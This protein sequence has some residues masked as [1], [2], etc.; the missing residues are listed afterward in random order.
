MTD[1]HGGSVMR[2]ILVALV[3][4]A[5]VSSAFAEEQSSRTFTRE[6]SIPQGNPLEVGLKVGEMEIQ[7]A[8]VDMVTVEIRARC[9]PAGDEKC[10]RRLEGI[11]AESV[12]DES[13]SSIRVT[14]VSKRYHRMEIEAKIT[15]P[16]SSPLAVKMYAG[17]LRVEGG[18][19]DLEI[20]VKYGDVTVHQPQEATQSVLADAN[21]G[22]AQI[23]ASV[24]DTNPRRPWLVGSKVT[25]DGGEGDATVT[26]NLSAGEATVHLD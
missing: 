14:G 21:F 16:E 20:R 5:C 1:R 19:Q 2:R 10:Y 25:W 26:V 23:Y 3:V 17:E 24:G 13:G 15:V 7:T 4:V 9:R 6:F 11:Q 8:D 12:V 22:D 18:G